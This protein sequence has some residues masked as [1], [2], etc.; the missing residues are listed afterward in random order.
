[1][2]CRTFAILYSLLPR[3]THLFFF[4]FL[5]PRKQCTAKA[6]QK[7]NKSSILLEMDVGTGISAYRFIF[8]FATLHVC[9]LR[10]ISAK[11]H[12]F[13]KYI[14]CCSWHA[15]SL[16]FKYFIFYFVFCIV[17]C[18]PQYH[19]YHLI[20]LVAVFIQ[21]NSDKYIKK[22]S[23]IIVIFRYFALRNEKKVSVT[24]TMHTERARKK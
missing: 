23:V 19:H 7:L 16:L 1:M 14:C 5:V 4:F 8:K 12:F 18:V 9:V 22:K 11:L 24:I 17:L 13:F 20:S 10:T 3:Y 6:K 2:F 15:I 21:K